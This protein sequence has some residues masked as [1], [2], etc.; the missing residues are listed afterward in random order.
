MFS[1]ASLPTHGI[2]VAKVFAVLLYLQTPVA[3][4][5][6]PVE[7]TKSVSAAVA[8]QDFFAQISAANLEGISRYVRPEGFSEFAPEWAG[9]KQLDLKAF[10]G[11]FKSGVRVDL[12]LV[13]VKTLE[14][15]DT[16]IVTCTRVGTITPP[17]GEPIATQL[18]FTMV[19][20]KS[21]TEW[22]S[23]TPIWR[24]WAAAPRNIPERLDSGPT[25]RNESL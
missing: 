10:E 24:R 9:L 12:Q 22:N 11:L 19:W 23:S 18:A 17:N 13:D 3:S 15:G 7:S 21:G 5:A 1:L 6:A 20:A 16:A 8:A 2:R 4:W 25:Q 14:I